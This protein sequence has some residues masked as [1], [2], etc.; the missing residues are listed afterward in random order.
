MTRA[1]HIL[2]LSV[3]LLLATAGWAPHATPLSLSAHSPLRLLA[4]PQLDELFA[5]HRAAVST[6]SHAGASLATHLRA[7][8]TGV[9]VRTHV[10]PFW[11][12]TVDGYDDIRA[13]AHRFGVSLQYLEDLNPGV[14]LASVNPGDR[15]LV[16][17]FD[18][19]AP[20]RSVGSANR[21]YL[22]GGMPLPGGDHWIVRNTSRAWGTPATIRS[23]IAGFY[24]VGEQLPGGS[25]PMVGDISH[26]EGG[27]IRP[28]KSHRTGRDVDAAYYSLTDTAPHFWDA[29]S[30]EHDVA[31]TWA[32]FRY[33]IE[34]DAV[35]YIFADTAIQ[36]SL[37]DYAYTV[38]D[39][40][41]FIR[42]ALQVEGGPRAI[43]RHARGHAGHF[44]VRFR[45]SVW[46]PTCQ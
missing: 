20:P 6:T 5:L 27:P 25:L 36:R 38:G 26:P 39:D 15:I 14:E 12:E 37:A 42:R 17:R 16:Y 2:A 34:N 1:L 46:D 13:K 19:G 40:P 18:P 22:V 44:H 23:L 7:Q 45:C 21:G 8:A 35:E 33:W 4:G 31:R 30:V 32:L 9:A 43:I 24:H 28:H 11:F 3:A 29:R 41:A 10:R